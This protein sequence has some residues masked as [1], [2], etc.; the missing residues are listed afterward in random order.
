M[1]KAKRK[2]VSPRS[3]DAK[4][5]TLTMKPEVLVGPEPVVELLE[6]GEKGHDGE[7]IPT[8]E[9]PITFFSRYREDQ[10]V[11]EQARHEQVGPQKWITIPAKICAFRD[12]AFVTNNK[13]KIEFI[14]KHPRYGFE[15]FEFGNDDHKSRIDKIDDSGRIMELEKQGRLA[16]IMESR[17]R[18]GLDS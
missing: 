14:R 8:T 15:L 9:K 3:G 13:E 16:R 7:T 1:T 6:K 2:P 12:R 4:P 10:L 17:I 5:E 11:I 18:R